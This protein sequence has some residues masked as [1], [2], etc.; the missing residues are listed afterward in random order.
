[1]S[2][3]LT[4]AIFEGITEL[5]PNLASPKEKIPVIPAVFQAGIALVFRG[6]KRF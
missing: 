5:R 1:V 2:F 6:A 4:K 3:N